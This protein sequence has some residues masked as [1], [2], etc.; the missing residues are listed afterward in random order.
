MTTL[1][2]TI[3]VNMTVFEDP[4]TISEKTILDG[5]FTVAQQTDG[6]YLVTHFYDISNNPTVDILDSPGS[7]N[8]TIGNRMFNEYEKND[9]NNFFDMDK[10]VFAEGGISITSFPFFSDKSNKF[11]LISVPTNLA[12]DYV[13]GDVDHFHYPLTFVIK[14]EVIDA[15]SNAVD[16]IFNNIVVSEN[17]VNGEIVEEPA[18][19]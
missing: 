8:K 11:A 12:R 5:T 3:T 2:Y 17:I 7:F 13:C 16:T 9:A 10:N 19:N 14:P 15:S 1:N 6:N 18:V 4:M